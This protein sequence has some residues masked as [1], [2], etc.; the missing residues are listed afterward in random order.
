MDQP[1][2]WQDKRS[3][4][5]A[6]AGLRPQKAA[7]PGPLGKDWQTKKETVQKHDL[8]LNEQITR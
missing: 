8:F 2:I 6:Q 7:F 3:F 1:S 5:P 4:P